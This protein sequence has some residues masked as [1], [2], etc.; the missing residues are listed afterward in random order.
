MKILS[1]RLVGPC[2]FKQENGSCERHN[3][4][5][6][7]SLHLKMACIK[8]ASIPVKFAPKKKVLSFSPPQWKNK[9]GEFT[10]PDVLSWVDNIY[11]AKAFA[12]RAEFN[13]AYDEKDE[14][15]L[16]WRNKTMI[17]SVEDVNDLIEE[18][19]GGAFDDGDKVK[20][21][22][23]IKKLRAVIETGEKAIFVY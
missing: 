8:F 3:W 14:Y 4:L 1:I 13:Q 22:K 2:P 5:V 16:H 6:P 23:L 17:L 15:R 11:Q 9:M 10:D 7:E 21:T 19:E 18:Y 12:S 20:M